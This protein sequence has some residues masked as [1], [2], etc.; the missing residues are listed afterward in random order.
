MLEKTDSYQLKQEDKKMSE[1]QPLSVIDGKTLLG[2]DCEPP[3]FIVSRLLPA[4]LSI[5]SGSAKVGKSWLALWLCQQVAKGEPV[6]GFDTLQCKV[7]YL[8]L[9]DTIDRLHFRLSSITDEGSEDSFFATSA[10]NL[11]G[12]LIAQLESFITGKPDT[13]LIVIDTL[14]R[15]RGTAIDKNAYALD[16]EDMGKIK[17][18][19]DKMN[20][21]IL[22]IHHVRK[23]PDSDPFNMVSGS[24]GIVGSADAMYVLEKERRLDNQAI[25][26]VTGRDV[27]DMQLLLEF[28]RERTV[29]NFLSFVSG[30]SNPADNLLETIGRLISEKGEFIGTASELIKELKSYTSALVYSPNA[31]SRII[32]ENRLTLEKKHRVRADFN[33]T[34]TS[35]MIWLKAIK[36]AESDGDTCFIP[37]P[38]PYLSSP[39]PDDDTIE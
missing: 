18:I 6:W 4:G 32:R 7:L 26:H 33:R 11:S 38:Q 27:E 35:R 16:Y 31:L 28:D 21:A 3:K 5:L 36:M 8:A 20:I 39:V 1:L 2:L 15:I 37:T 9:E 13:G 12:T 25:L 22:L 10:D 23:M 19:A 34:K 14:Q 24:T 30:G 17:A 29:W